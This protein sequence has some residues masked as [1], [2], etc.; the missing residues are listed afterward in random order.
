MRKIVIL[1]TILLIVF[2]LSAQKKPGRAPLNPEY[3]KYLESQKFFDQKKYTGDKG[4]GYVPSPL[5][6][7]FDQTKVLMDSKKSIASFPA[8]YDL[9]DSM[10]VT[11]YGIGRDSVKDQGPA[12]ACWTFSTVGAIES[13]WLKLGKPYTDLSELNMATCHGF[14]SGVDDGGNNQ[15]AL[16]YLTRLKGPVTEESQP[17]SP[18]PSATCKTTDL[19]KTAYILS[20]SSIPKNTDLV[21]KAIMDYGAL[22]ASIHIGDYQNYLSLFNYTYCYPGNEAVDHA[23]LIIGW[24]DNKLVTGGSGSP[25]SSRGA[26]IVKNSWGTTFADDGYFYVGYNDTKILSS[27]ICFPERIELNEVDTL[28]MYDELGSITSFGYGEETGIGLV[29]YTAPEEHFIN[30]I[31]TFLNTYSSYVDIEIYSN[32]QDGNLTGLLASSYNNHRQFPG[33]YTFD[34]PALVNGDFYVK[35]KYT[36]PG[37]GY[38]IPAEVTIEPTA[39]PDIQEPGKCWISEDGTEWIALGE[40]IENFDADLSIRVYAERKPE[41]QVFFTASKILTCIES[42]V[43]FTDGSRGNIVSYE[44]DFGTDATPATAASKGPHEVHWTSAGKKTISLKVTDNQDS[45]KTMTKTNYIEV[46]SELD[47]ILPFTE[48]TVVKRRPLTIYAAGAENYTWSPVEGLNTTTGPV[49]IATPLESTTYTVTGTIGTCTGTASIE[50]EVLPN[51][52]N[53]D[54]CDAIQ[55]NTV[56]FQGPYTNV[57]ATVEANEPC[58]PEGDC[59]TPMQWCVEGGLHNSVWFWFIGS[60]TGIISIN[61]EGMDNQIAVYDAILC[62]SILSSTGH[63]MVAANDDYYGEDKFFA[64]AIDKFTVVH[65]KKYFLQVDGSAGGAEGYFTIKMSEYPINREKIDVKQNSLTNVTIYPNPGSGIFNIR[66]YELQKGTIM[67]KV[68]NLTGQ[69]V[70]YRQV[71]MTGIN[72]TEID[73]SN[74]SSGLY[75]LEL[76]DKQEFYRQ[77]IVIE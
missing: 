3:V 53:D 4:Y 27:S 8:K 20:S 5:Y 23:I 47:I 28:Y 12:G 6:I 31:G 29:K 9:R 44:W 40:G 46:K 77:T 19:V 66:F 58:P 11:D 34:L 75:L 55:L 67:M 39:T 25:P 30:K 50:L 49:V 74:V 59:N 1:F 21:K 48:K 24:D 64:A 16:A 42:S 18:D 68:F 13:N 37:Y 57:N 14:N 52:V 33:Y 63:T 60:E 17:Y 56:G 54:V 45:S 73:L 43:I 26:W 2:N 71:D 62:D 35:I 72:K 61:T 32:F 38:P 22:S 65:N 7:H 36:S 51:P 76:S 69:T 15:F 70:F 10:L 41:Y